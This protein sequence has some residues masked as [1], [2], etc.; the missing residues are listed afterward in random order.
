MDEHP[1]KRH[2]EARPHARLQPYTKP[3]CLSVVP[4]VK[5]SCK[6]FRTPTHL[7]SSPPP[8]GREAPAPCL[9]AKAKSAQN[10]ASTV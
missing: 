6:A 10:L 9:A 2:V 7:Y 3:K 8:M 5:Q 1:S 4:A